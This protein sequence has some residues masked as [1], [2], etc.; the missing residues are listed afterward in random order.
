LLGSLLDPVVD[1]VLPGVLDTVTGTV[2]GLTG[3]VGGLVH[4]VSGTV[5]GLT[6]G[7]AGTVGGV[8][9]LVT[10]TVDN[11]LPI[12]G[13]APLDVDQLQ[14]I[15]AT[16]F[17]KA[18]DY[19][20]KNAVGDKKTREEFLLQLRNELAEYEDG[21]DGTKNVARGLLKEFTDENYWES[22]AVGENIINKALKTLNDTKFPDF[23]SFRSARDKMTSDIQRQLQKNVAFHDLSERLA[24]GVEALSTKLGLQF[25]LSAAEK[26][27]ELLLAIE[28]RKNMEQQKKQAELQKGLMGS[29]QLQTNVET[30]RKLLAEQSERQ[31]R[32]WKARVDLESRLREQQIES[33]LET[34]FQDRATHLSAE[35]AASQQQMMMTMM[36]M[37]KEANETEM[38]L[39]SLMLEKSKKTPPMSPPTP[40]VRNQPGL[41]S[42]LLS[43]VTGLVDSFH[44]L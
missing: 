44:L 24:K 27:K 28:Y 22:L 40:L 38:K 42:S 30:E 18:Y 37:R 14:G 4:T 10:T 12:I 9:N 17:Q 20:K 19:Y 21:E 16:A 35:L 7:L 29:Q 2:G 25:G 5:G 36:Q 39:A 15:S 31:F 1:T 8:L 23:E 11:V 41:L 13:T 3:T 32:E 34:G 26:E 6:E 43:P 33:D